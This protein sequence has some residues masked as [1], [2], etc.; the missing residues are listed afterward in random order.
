MERVDISGDKLEKL[1]KNEVP[2]IKVLVKKLDGQKYAVIEEEGDIEMEVYK[3]DEDEYV[4][5]VTKEIGD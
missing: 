3:L 4:D 5:T 2:T 1:T